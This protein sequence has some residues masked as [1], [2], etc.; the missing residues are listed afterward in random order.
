[1]KAG[2]T[3]TCK[4]LWYWS[5]KMTRKQKENVARY[6]SFFKYLTKL[7]LKISLTNWEILSSNYLRHEAINEPLVITPK[8]KP[9]TYIKQTWT[10][11]K[12]EAKT[13]MKYLCYFF[14]F[15]FSLQMLLIEFKFFALPHTKRKNYNE[16]VANAISIISN[17]SCDN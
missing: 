1:M 12:K 6:F 10:T 16:K 17:N 2:V 9:F 15:F 13:I 3:V 11:K 7:L 8:K 14:F 4:Y 5:M